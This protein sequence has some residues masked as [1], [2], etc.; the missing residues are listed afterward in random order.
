MYR[1]SAENNNEGILTE[2]TLY[3][4]CSIEE[5]CRGRLI[6]DELSRRCKQPT[7]EPCAVHK[8]CTY[9]NQCLDYRCHPFDIDIGNIDENTKNKSK[10]RSSKSRSSKSRSSKKFAKVSFAKY[11]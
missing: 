2:G 11:K 4:P 10:S 1:I 8:D 9:G 3:N 5:P 7:G 6:C